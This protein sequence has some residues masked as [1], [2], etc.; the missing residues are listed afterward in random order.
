MMTAKEIHRAVAA[1]WNS[2]DFEG[3]RALM[4]PEYT[5]MG[6]D[7]KEH[8]GPAAGIAIAQMYAG[9]FG[10]GRLDVLRVYVDG[11]TAVAEMR[12]SGTHTGDLM[13][14]PPTHKRMETLICN[15]MEVRDGKIYREREYLDSANLMAQLGLSAHA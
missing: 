3:M 8:A 2:R 5:Y 15:V 6:G 1:A 10:D 12:A 13:G 9:A 7:G 4:H 11:D 14:A